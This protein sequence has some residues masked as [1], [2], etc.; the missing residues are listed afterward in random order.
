M[1]S[2]VVRTRG[3][4]RVF[5]MKN[6]LSHSF[7]V[8]SQSFIRCI[9]EVEVKPADSAVIRPYQEIISFR[10]DRKARVPMRSGHKFFRQNLQKSQ[11]FLLF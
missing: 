1:L 4:Q 7:L 8:I 6:D 5:P 9:R 2:T 10:M 11:Q 3:K